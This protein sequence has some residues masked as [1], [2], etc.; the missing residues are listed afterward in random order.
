MRS[1]MTCTY[2]DTECTCPNGNWSCTEPVAMGCPETAP[3]HGD[4]C[5]GRADCDFLEVECECLRGA[6][7]CKQ[8]D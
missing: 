6:W 5:V 2:E 7:S 1:S 8:N 4:R 3:L